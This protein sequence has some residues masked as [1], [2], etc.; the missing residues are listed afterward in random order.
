MVTNR[1]LVRIVTEIRK[2]MIERGVSSR[3]L[4]KMCNNL[5]YPVTR[6]K[7]LRAFS[8]ENAKQSFLNNTDDT[9][10]A[11]LIAFGCTGED[12]L[13]RILHEDD[14]FNFDPLQS[15]LSDDLIAF[16]NSPEA[17]PYLKLAYAQYKAKLAKKEIEDLQHVLDF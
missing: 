13:N 8:V 2:I 6:S 3:Q 1:L 4:E 5:G 11:T 12:I 16:V 9:I 7:I 14:L 10:E 17:V 15:H